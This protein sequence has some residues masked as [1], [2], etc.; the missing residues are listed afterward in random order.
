[1]DFT[2]EPIIETV[3]TPKEGC[4]LVIRSSRGAGQEE[5]FVDAVEVVSF[6]QSF[7]F[8]SME[9]PKS[10][11]VP[12]TDYEVLEVRETR[13]VLKSVHVEK[14]VKPA[15][16]VRSAKEIT[17]K[18]GVKKAPEPTNDSP[19]VEPKP[20]K[21]REKRRSSRR[22]RLREE[23]ATTGEE[24]ASLVDTEDSEPISSQQEIQLEEVAMKEVPPPF[25]AI[26]P[27]PD[28]LIA[29]T[30]SRYRDDELY[31]NAFFTRDEEEEQ[32][33]TREPTHSGL[34][35]EI[36]PAEVDFPSTD[37][38]SSE[39]TPEAFTYSETSSEE[40]EAATE[41][42]F[43]L[44]EEEEQREA[45][46]P[47]FPPLAAEDFTEEKETVEEASEAIKEEAEPKTEVWHEEEESS[48]SSVDGNEE[49]KD[50]GSTIGN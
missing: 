24:K 35:P 44:G 39:G 32:E 20:E 7:F 8:R 9:R 1:M 26:L 48:E 36:P 41:P 23:K 2:R 17:E 34:S 16:H 43:F 37:E 3:I 15:S 13:M 14:S 50:E 45:S 31:R 11:I 21:K 28:T 5:F 4:K 40:E 12:V 6:G 10:F 22:R 18:K 33:D 42:D 27:P 47:S 19:V 29:E 25:S 30:I 46:Y 38:E 49:R